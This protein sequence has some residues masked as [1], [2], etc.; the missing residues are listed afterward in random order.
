MITN[1]KRLNTNSRDSEIPP[2]LIKYEFE[3]FHYTV[4][5]TDLTSMW[6]ESLDRKQIVKR[7]L[8]VDTSI[9][10][11]ENNE[12]FKI[13][14]DNLEKALNEEGAT[15]LALC[16]GKTPNQIALHTSTVLPASLAP[17]LWSFDLDPAPRDLLTTQLLVP[18]LVRQSFARAQIISLI[19]QI[20]EKDNM[21]SRLLDKM[22][23]DGVDLNKLFPGL[24]GLKSGTKSDV[25]DR[26]SQFIKGLGV[27][28]EE[29]WR[30]DLLKNTV[31]SSDMSDIFSQVF[32]PDFSDIPEVKYDRFGRVWWQRLKDE[33][34]Q[35][36][37]KT[38]SVSLIESKV[39]QASIKP[40]NCN[41]KNDDI[42]VNP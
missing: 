1:W 21:I 22:Q 4:F 9:D 10:P 20:K 37:E 13:L 12:Q 40:E 11:S 17:L 6:T 41:T 27:F 36:K 34:F 29:N 33:G 24:A 26:G 31:F 42:Q 15:K 7:A 35:E 18:C 19:R 8:I 25:R 32:A 3:T 28:N 39:A 30:R 38:T 14:L 5:V 2:L 23:A 16:K